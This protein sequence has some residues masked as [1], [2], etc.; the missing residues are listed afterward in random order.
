MPDPHFPPTGVS[1][2]RASDVLLTVAIE[3]A[4]TGD[5]DAFR[6]VY[7]AVQPRLLNYLRA[8][9]GETDAEDIAS[10]T[11]ARVARD[12]R[13]FT[14]DADG[15][16]GWT[17]TIARHRAIDQLRRRRPTLPLEEIGQRPAADDTEQ[18]ATDSLSTTAALA[19]IAQLPHEQAQAI[20]LR[21]VIGLDAASA[22]RILDKKPGAIRT[23]AH[24]GLRSLAGRLREPV[25][26]GNTV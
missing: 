9:V 22:G 2:N 24:R 16:R 4:R 19:L 26:S 7:R 1:S 11:W 23:A 20:L 5:E 25:P 17:T 8:M 21:V 14:G 3:R 12:I 6:L 18:A 15:F 13:S 10:E